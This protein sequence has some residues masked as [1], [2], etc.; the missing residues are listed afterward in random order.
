MKKRILNLLLS[1]MLVVSL[2]GT[3]AVYT[4]A[5]Y[6]ASRSAIGSSRAVTK[7]IKDATVSKVTNKVYTGKQIKPTVTVKY[8][9][10][11]LAKGTDYT[12]TYGTNKSIGKGTITIK[13]KGK[14][15]GSKQITFKVVPKKPAFS[16]TSAKKT[17]IYLKWSKPTGATK[18]QVAYRRSGNST[19]KK[20]TTSNNYITL[21]DLA[22]GKYYQ[23]KVRA[24]KVVNGTKYYSAWSPVKEV[25]TL[26][27]SGSTSGT[28]SNP[29]KTNTVYTT[30]TGK[31]Y[32]CTK[33]CSGLNNANKIYTS[34][35]SDAKA[36]GLTPCSKC[37]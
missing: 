25:K 6:D 23:I 22:S 8:N 16:K 31:K 18:Y 13:G 24:Y 19:Y 32:H 17:S 2:V 4:Q 36:R 14:Y 27:S 33:G 26:K 28:A 10:K 34:T 12:V 9:S 30:E 7:S 5:G 29:N 21:S 37:Y 3:S 11:K 35:L 20:K 15:Q 1:V